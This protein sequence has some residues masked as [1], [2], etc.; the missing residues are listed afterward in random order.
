MPAGCPCHIQPLTACRC[1]QLSSFCLLP[2]SL[3]LHASNNHY[4]PTAIHAFFYSLLLH[5]TVCHHL[6]L[7]SLPSHPTLPLYD[8]ICYYNPSSLYCLSLPVSFFSCLLFM[9]STACFCMSLSVIACHYLLP[10]LLL[11][12]LILPTLL[13]ST[14]LCHC[15]TLSAT[16]IL[17]ANC[18]AFIACLYLLLSAL[19]SLLFYEN[20]CYYNPSYQLSS[21]HCLSLSS[22]VCPP[23]SAIL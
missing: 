14:L 4:P 11:P 3:L 15:M 20:I 23:F 12:T 6:S 9:H 19:L 17:P 5:V 18:P 22:P 10:T 2:F 13:L 8:A 7:S 16:I 21:L 1:L